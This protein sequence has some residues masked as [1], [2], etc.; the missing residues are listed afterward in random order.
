MRAALVIV[1]A[2]CGSSPAPT[3]VAPTAPPHAIAKTSCADAGVI[4]R[5]VV[6]AQSP[7]APHDREL[8]IARACTDDHWPAVALDC[9]GASRVPFDC[10]G[11]HLSPQIVASY[12]IALAEW[13]AKY[14]ASSDLDPEPPPVSCDQVVA[15]IDK[16]SDDVTTERDWAIAARRRL[17]Q[18]GCMAGWSQTTRQ[19]ISAAPDRDAM[20]ACAQDLAAGVATIAAHAD[21]IASAKHTP[22]AIA[23]TR[24]SAAYYADAKWQDAKSLDRLS[25]ADRKKAIAG[26]RTAMVRACAKDGWDDTLR[27]C[28]ATGGDATCFADTNVVG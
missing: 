26:S 14:E 10:L 15:A 17:A 12:Q 9:I 20:L 3:T 7:E 4:L 21:A 16:L 1:V 18:A 28:L 8:A 23:C 25:P 27:A 22:K 5:G 13:A 19:C 6:E 11:K 2:A 24:V